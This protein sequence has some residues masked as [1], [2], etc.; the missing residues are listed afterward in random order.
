M[1]DGE[2]EP[3]AGIQQLRH[4]PRV[5]R[6]QQ[7]LGQR[8]TS[9][10]HGGGDQ[11]QDDVFGIMVLPSAVEVQRIFARCGTGL[12]MNRAMFVRKRSSGGFLLSGERS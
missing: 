3:R 2:T 10:E 11:R 5:G 4:H 7:Q 1:N 8:R 12:S 9:A 6:S